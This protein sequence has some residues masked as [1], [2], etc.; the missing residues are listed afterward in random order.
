MGVRR[1]A[2][3]RFN[4]FYIPEPNSGCWLWLGCL[5]RD[6]YP[7]F[8]GAEGSVV[9][10]HR[11]I[12]ELTRKKIPEGLTIDHLCRVRCCVNPDHMEVVSHVENMRRGTIWQYHSS[13]TECPKGHR[14][15][16]ENTY[17]RP[18]NQYRGAQRV[19]RECN[20]LAQIDYRERKKR[21]TVRRRNRSAS[22]A[23][24]GS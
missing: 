6:G 19:C 15:S 7:Q 14:F 9:R 17:L 21:G 4:D 5:T 13:K 22:A 18:A 16:P 10:A 1:S 3:D 12:F 20:R 23:D 8:Y 24:A 11:F 2:V